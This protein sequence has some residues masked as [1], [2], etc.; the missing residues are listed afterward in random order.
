MIWDDFG[1]IWGWF[2]DDL[3]IILGWFGDDFGDDLWII[4]DDYNVWNLRTITNFHRSIRFCFSAWTAQH[5]I[6]HQTMRKWELISPIMELHNINLS[7]LSM[8]WL[9]KLKGTFCC[10]L[11][12]KPWFS[13]QVQYSFP[14]LFPWAKSTGICRSGG[15][16]RFRLKIELGLSENGVPLKPLV[17]HY[18]PY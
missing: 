15:L 17:N 13:H 1:M 10:Y 8:D 6:C 12:L 11:R 18:F 5:R 9:T 7:W 2:W 3:W 4:L 16:F 14:Y